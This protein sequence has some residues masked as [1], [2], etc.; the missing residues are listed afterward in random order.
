MNVPATSAGLLRERFR[1]RG[2]VQGVGFRPFVYRLALELDL[3]GWVLNDAHGVLAEVQ[4]DA[5]LLEAFAHRLQADAPPLARVERV[6]RE[7]CSVEPARG[8][9]IESS[10]GGAA[11]T[12]VTPDAATCPDCLADLLDPANRRFR[13]PFT[14]CTHCGPRFTI[15]ERVPYDRPGTTMAPF[16]MC[17]DCER[18]YRDPLDRRFHAQPNACPVCGPRLAL[19]RADGAP[20]P[21]PDVIAAA[22]RLIEQGELVALKGLGGFHLACDA[23]N[24]EAVAS[25]R[26][27][28]GREEKPFAV[29]F[30]N[31]AS[32][33]PFAQ[34]DDD[35][36]ALLES[37]E[38]PIVLLDKLAGCDEVLAGRGARRLGARGDASLRA[39]ALPPLPCGEQGHGRHRVARLS[40]V[41]RPGHDQR[42]PGRRAA[43]HRQR[44]GG[45]PPRRHCRCLRRPRPR[46]LRALRRQRRAAHAERP[47]FRAPRARLHAAGDPPAARRALG[48]RLRRV[49]QE[50][51]LRHAGRRGVP[52]PAYRRPRQRRQLRSA[53]RSGLAPSR[54]PR[55]PAG[56]RRARPASG[57]LQHALCGALRR[58][59]TAFPPSPSSTTTRTSPRCA[60]SMAS[61]RR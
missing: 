58:A 37:R 12:P 9:T 15:T 14:N 34:I 36:R 22:L 11:A 21:E 16:A 27:A 10:R 41:P 59:S 2:T 40:P 44:G 8:F 55:G 5:S 46:H 32:I 38:R 49:A 43:R 56:G 39:A 25:L 20:Q 31:V 13:Y 33:S 42:E 3:D 18:E 54:H 53:R 50:H 48:A 23:R 47:G 7:P 60:R 35:A 51:G 52:V 61:R 24:A 57:L 28:K 4:G 1:V 30:A 29:M 17:P 19:L 26:A 45:A 6:E